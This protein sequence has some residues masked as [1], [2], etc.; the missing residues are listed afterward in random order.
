LGGAY[1]V[2]AMLAFFGGCADRLILF[3]QTGDAKPLGVRPHELPFEDGRLQ[4]WIADAPRGQEPQAFVLSF[5]GN[6]DRA[7]R[8]IVHEAL[9]WNAHPVEVWA[10]NYPGYGGS[11]GPAKLARLGPAGLVAYDALKQHAGDRPIFVAGNSLGTAVALHVAT[12][13]DV[14]GAVLVNPPPLRQLILGRWGWWNLWL[15][16]G[17]IAMAVPSDLNSVANARQ[18][19]APAV[20][21][22]STL[23]SVVPYK[24]QKMV[25]QAYAG[26]TQ[27]FTQDAN[28]NDPLT[29]E[30]ERTLRQHIAWLYTQATAGRE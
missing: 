30:G 15:I 19:T 9:L 23:D 8:A 5:N 28:H 24:W 3:P 22:L 11:T 10:V 18:A 2:F 6:A 21:T 29:T 14:A 16:A 1:I 12:Q 7:E 27:T 20:F 4:V 25:H 13:R 17:P 26:P